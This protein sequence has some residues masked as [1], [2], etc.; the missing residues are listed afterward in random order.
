[1]QTALGVIHTTR[2]A[3]GHANSLYL[4]VHGT[5]GAI[6]LDLEKSYNEVEVC[7]SDDIHKAK[8]T[9]LD[10]LQTP[11]IHERFIAAVRTGKQG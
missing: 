9:T 5:K 11:N 4:R 2:W 10:D 8:W 7:P 3:T 1:M 6:K